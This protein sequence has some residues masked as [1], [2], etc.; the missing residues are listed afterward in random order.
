MKL[1]TA[2]LIAAEARW[3]KPYGC[4]P[5]QLEHYK[6]TDD[7]KKDRGFNEKPDENGV[8]LEKKNNRC[9]RQCKYGN[10]DPTTYVT[11]RCTKNHANKTF[12]CAYKMKLVKT[13]RGWVDFDYQ[14][15]GQYPLDKRGQG[16]RQAAC[17]PPGTEGEWGEWS[18]WSACDGSCGLGEATRT[19]Q[20]STEYCGEGESEQKR[21]CLSY[22]QYAWLWRHPCGRPSTSFY[23]GPPGNGILKN[24]NKG[25]HC[26]FPSFGQGWKEETIDGELVQMGV[27]CE[28]EEGVDTW[29]YD[30]H[31]ITK[32][33]NRCKIVCKGANGGE[34]L[35]KTSSYSNF[36]CLEPIPVQ[37][38]NP[39]A[40]YNKWVEQGLNG[41]ENRDVTQWYYNQ[42][43]WPRNCYPGCP[44]FK[45]LKELSEEFTQCYKVGAE[46]TCGG[47]PPRTQFEIDMGQTGEGNSFDCTDGDK[48]GSICTKSCIN[49][50][51]RHIGNDKF[52]CKCEGEA[53]S[54]E[55]TD[56]YFV[57]VVYQKRQLSCI[58]GCDALPYN[59]FRK[60][61][62]VLDCSE[63]NPDLTYSSSSNNG[64][65]IIY[66]WN[67]PTP[68]LPDKKCKVTCD[69]PNPVN[70]HPREWMMEGWD[71]T[72]IGHF[73]IKCQSNSDG[74][75]EWVNAAGGEMKQCIPVCYNF[76]R[77]R[78]ED[79]EV[80]PIWKCTKNNFVGSKC[81]KKCPDGYKLSNEGNNRWKHSN[82]QCKK[83]SY[84]TSWT[85]SW[86]KACV[87]A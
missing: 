58:Q 3:K 41:L 48:P 47:M 4:D 36:H 72:G 81:T 33:G 51:L 86:F 56:D 32:D 6:L 63:E 30:T 76:S 29:N 13:V 53:C 85:N 26:V 20:C 82:T 1:L 75:F 54:W 57:Y 12:E 40:G 42:Q 15:D 78:T 64:D 25:T 17:I 74:T 50:H 60:K 73:D 83:R 24:L 8:V 68:V 2:I 19:R 70:G 84:G 7:C 45:S 87:R 11:C 18:D 16:G 66:Q 52:V 49:N 62:Y 39:D 28:G 27:E 35:P 5:A 14:L 38:V 69:D 44:N 9:R 34:Y 77:G 21:T 31:S 65:A 46:P 71:E 55:R 43:T 61:E 67:N 10:L 59:S 23:Y 37:Y 79:D 22:D 80:D